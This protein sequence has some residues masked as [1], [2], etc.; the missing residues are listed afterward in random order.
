MRYV[1]EKDKILFNLDIMRG[2]CEKS[3]VICVIK[4]NGYG[5]GLLNMASILTEGGADFFAVSR[6]EEALELRRAGCVCRI[7]LL[8]PP[9]SAQSAEEI[10]RN[11]IIATID[12]SYTAKLLDDAAIAT[13]KKASAHFIIDTGFG[14]YGFLPGQENDIIDAFNSCEYVSFEGIYTHF[15]NSFSNDASSV[16]Y[17]AAQF[18]IITKALENSGVTWLMKHA[19]SSAA[20]VKYPRYHYDA[21]RLGSALLGRVAD[22]NG[23]PLKEVGHLESEIISIKELPAGHNLGYGEVFKTKR[24]T[25]CAVIPAGTIDGVGLQRA[26]VAFTFSQKVFRILRNILKLRNKENLSVEINGRSFPVIGKVGLTDMFVD[27]S[28]SDDV[29]IGDKVKIR[30]SPIML[31]YSVDIAVI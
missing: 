15:Y 20:A 2:H 11:D 24:R 12:S 4:A 25:L 31:N 8:S 7:L 26:D 1:V 18:D 30:I 14:R 23:L 29:R 3:N 22:K 5:L 17:Q 21:V 13:Q 10:C 27:V 6:L 9:Y 16:D 28:G 19:C